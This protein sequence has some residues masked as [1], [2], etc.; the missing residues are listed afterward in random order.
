MRWAAVQICD[1]LHLIRLGFA[2]PPS[3]HRGRQ[4]AAVGA[5]QDRGVDKRGRI[6]IMKITEGP[7]TAISG[8]P[9]CMKVKRAY[10]SRNRHLPE[11]RFLPFMRI[12]T[13]SPKIWNV[14]VIGIGTPP[15]G[16]FQGQ[17]ALR[18]LFSV[19]GS[20]GFLRTRFSLS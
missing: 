13:V 12:V 7:L 16:G 3:P 14:S 2:E 1:C 9:R 11:W 8:W 6:G 17:T 10:N 18:A 20:S 15:F 5:G 19:S 4:G